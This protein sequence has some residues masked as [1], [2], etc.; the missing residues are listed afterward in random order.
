MTQAQQVHFLIILAL[1]YTSLLTAG[2]FQA[3]LDNKKDPGIIV[4]GT[5]SIGLVVG[6]I[7]ALY[8]GV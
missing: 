7:L 6:F 2:F 5:F 1:A 3:W 4:L 8:H